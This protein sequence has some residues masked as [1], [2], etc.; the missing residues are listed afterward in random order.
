MVSETS[1]PWGFTAPGT[2]YCI[3]SNIGIAYRR[4]PVH[5]CTTHLPLISVYYSLCLMS[6][7]S[8]LL[9][10]LH[11]IIIWYKWR[12]NMLL[13]QSCSRNKAN[14]GICGLTVRPAKLACHRIP[15][16]PPVHVTVCYWNT[17]PLNIKSRLPLSFDI[18]LYDVQKR[19]FSRNG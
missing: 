4:R 13:V 7:I 1:S 11:F 18:L 19:R 12:R 5:P 10:P 9:Y 8:S 14:L 15:A 16:C 3:I 2:N 6:Y 17:S